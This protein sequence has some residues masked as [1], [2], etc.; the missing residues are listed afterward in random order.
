[1]FVKHKKWTVYAAETL[2]AAEI[3]TLVLPLLLSLV[4][5]TLFVNG[6]TVFGFTYIV[7]ANVL[8]VLP[9]GFK[10]AEL[11]NLAK[12]PPI[13]AKTIL[14]GLGKPH[15]FGAASSLF[16]RCEVDP[17]LVIIG[18]CFIAVST[19]SMIFGLF[20]EVR[21]RRYMKREDEHET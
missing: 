5:F 10:G 8:N 20:L 9:L 3:S 19:L 7:I 21:T 12:N 4:P 6:E 17:N 11:I 14:Y 1:M 16:L 2:K 15:T 18:G 13:R